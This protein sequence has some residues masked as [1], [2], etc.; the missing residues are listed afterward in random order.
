V[1]PEGDDDDGTLVKAGAVN[2]I[3]EEFEFSPWMYW[4]SLVHH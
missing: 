2:G 1:S 4:Y 3:I